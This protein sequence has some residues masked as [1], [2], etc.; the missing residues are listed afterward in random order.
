MDYYKIHFVISNSSINPPAPVGI[1][2][3]YFK[4]YQIGASIPE[5][6]TSLNH[7]WPAKRFLRF[8]P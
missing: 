5:G 6:F 8:A 1:G 2:S 7:T 4:L 3:I